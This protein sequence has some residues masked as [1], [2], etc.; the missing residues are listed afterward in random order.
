MAAIK[1]QMVRMINIWCAYTSEMGA[2]HITYFLIS[3]CGNMATK[4]YKLGWHV[5]EY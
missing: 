2:Y 4:D 5:T 3:V 1:Q